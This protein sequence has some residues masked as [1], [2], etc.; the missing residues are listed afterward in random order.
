MYY[1]FESGGFFL[2]EPAQF[3]SREIARGIEEPRKAYV[4]AEFL[5]SFLSIGDT[6]GIAPY[7]GVAEHIF[8]AVDGH[9]TVHL[10]ADSDSLYIGWIDAA[11]LQHGSGG[12]LKVLPPVGGILFSPALFESFY[13]GLAFREE[14][15]GHALS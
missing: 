13:M 4:G 8:V 1:L 3:C 9:E 7:D 14:I 15:G 2:L 5:E 10:V 12:L 11:F 6:T